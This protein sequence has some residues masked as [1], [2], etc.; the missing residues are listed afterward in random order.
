MDLSSGVLAALVAGVATPESGMLV[1]SNFSVSAADESFLPSALRT[2]GMSANLL[3]PAPLP[4][5]R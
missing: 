2:S 1:A 3:T 5:S 4:P